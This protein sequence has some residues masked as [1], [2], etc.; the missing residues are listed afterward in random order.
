MGQ[1]VVNL[2]NP[3]IWAFAPEKTAQSWNTLTS[4]VKTVF[5]NPGAVW[6]AFKEPFVKD[7]TEGRPGAAI[8]RGV[9][10]VGSLFVGTKGLDKLAKGS[11]LVTLV[12]DA[13]KVGT[14][15]DDAAKV[16]TKLDD[17][18]AIGGKT[19][20]VAKV[21]EKTDDVA[22]VG[23]KVEEGA[24]LGYQLDPKKFDYFFGK[25]E[26]PPDALKATDPKQY[27]KLMHNYNRSQ[28]LKGVFERWASRTTRTV[29]MRY[30]APSRRAWTHPS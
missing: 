24:G 14:K 10:E 2:T 16:G 20:D 13:A 1:G 5:T 15:L 23:E 8:G 27:E 11:K 4:A 28:Q 22:K 12:D 3:L 30:R 9:F 6:D 29:R 17:V 19:D 26:R 25:V 21:G 18:G 7:W